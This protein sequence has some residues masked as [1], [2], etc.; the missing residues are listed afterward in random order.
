MW[1]ITAN[2]FFTDTTNRII[3]EEAKDREEVEDFV[4]RILDFPLT[5]SAI[6]TVVVSP[7]KT[8]DD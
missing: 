1:K 6:F 4:W 3:T 2:I 8:H 5:S 7:F